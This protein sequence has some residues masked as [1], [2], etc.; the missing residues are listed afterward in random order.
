MMVTDASISAAN[1][2]GVIFCAFLLAGCTEQTLNV[3]V[4]NYWPRPMAHVY[5]D[6]QHVGAGFGE[7]GPGGT[8]GSISC[9]YCS[10]FFEG[11]A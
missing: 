7:Y 2:A 5:V 10:I 9:C 6:G 11:G 4:F 3:V 8:G 1:W